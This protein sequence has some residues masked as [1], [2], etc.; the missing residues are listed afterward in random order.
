MNK[1]ESVLG[2]DLGTSSVKVLQRYIDGTVVKAKATYDEIS[3]DAWWKAIKHALAGLQL[4]DVV[5]IGLSSQVGT[6]IVDDRDVISWNCSIG[7]EELE[8]IRNAYSTEDFVEEISMPHPNIVSY[9]I[10]RLLYIKKQYPNVQ[11]VCQPKDFICEKLTGNWVTDPYSWRGLAN[12][13]TKEYS[14]KFLNVIGIEKEVLP[15]I[16]DYMDMAGYTVGIELEDNLLPK[17]IPVYIGLNDYFASLLGMGIENVGDMF[18]ISG[19][20]EHLGIIEDFINMDT[21]MVSGPY[22]NANVHYG[23]TASSGASLDFGLRLVEDGYVKLE[24][25]Q[26]HQPPIFLPYLNGERAPIW[27]ANAKGMFFGIT[28]KCTKEDMMYSVMEGVVFSLYHIY[29]SM[30][31]PKA[32]KMK[33]AGGAAVNQTINQLKAEMFEI[34]VAVLVENDTSA[35]GAALVAATGIGWFENLKNAIA[36]VCKIKEHIEPTG[37]YKAWLE[38]RFAIYKELYPAVKKQYEEFRRVSQ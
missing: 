27:D 18:D 34:P 9:P 17:G 3:H 25:M 21:K 11:R 35:L 19:T 23:V 13:E 33:I 29:E 7:S 1:R 2:I 28:A 16:V 32:T 24:E 4:E 26:K 8:Q 31:K 5:A 6:Y 38:N 30:G 12:L 36:K 14:R 10:P 15:E 37:E 22:L 20:S